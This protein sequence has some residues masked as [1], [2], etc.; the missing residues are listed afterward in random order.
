[1]NTEG[2]PDRACEHGWRAQDMAET[3][4]PARQSCAPLTLTVHFRGWNLFQAGLPALGEPHPFRCPPSE[5]KRCRPRPALLLVTSIW[6][7]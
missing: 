2:G 6:S 4:L 1:M 5:D 7:P 3:S